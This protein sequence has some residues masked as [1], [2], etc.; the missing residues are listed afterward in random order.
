[1]YKKRTIII[2][3][4]IALL[5]LITGFSLFSTKLTI[6]GISEVTSS[7]KV[8]FE[9]INRTSTEGAA[10]EASTPKIY[11]TSIEFEVNLRKPGDSITYTAVLKNGGTIDAIVNNIDASV[12]ATESS[13]YTVTGIKKG[14]KLAAGASKEITIKVEYDR[15]FTAVPD[16]KTN[17]LIINIE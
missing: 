1:M 13:T 14:D 2:A 6:N 8:Y 9:S 7:W 5:L 12:T 4:C 15:D 3:M 16:E 10:S 11:N 17:D